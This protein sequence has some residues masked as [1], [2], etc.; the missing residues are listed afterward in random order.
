MLGAVLPWS[1]LS[2]MES[3]RCVGYLFGSTCQNRLTSAAAVQQIRV[4]ALSAVPPCLALEGTPVG[5]ARTPPV[6]WGLNSRKAV[7]GPFGSDSRYTA[8]MVA[9]RVVNVTERLVA[10]GWNKVPQET[11]NAKSRRVAWVDARYTSRRPTMNVSD[12]P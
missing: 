3:W 5:P 1:Y 9:E 2:A 11:Y 12:C 4:G 7:G 10:E 6:H 8:N